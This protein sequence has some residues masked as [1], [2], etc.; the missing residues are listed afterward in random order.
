MNIV[1]L[2]L[3]TFTSVIADCGPSDYQTIIGESRLY[4]VISIASDISPTTNDNA[5]GIVANI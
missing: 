1:V 4:N 5:V 3:L 2:I